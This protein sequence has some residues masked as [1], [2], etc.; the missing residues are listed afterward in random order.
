[1]ER[2]DWPGSFHGR[3]AHLEP[4]TSR[5]V[6]FLIKPAENLAGFNFH[7]VSSQLYASSFWMSPASQALVQPIPAMNGTA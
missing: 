6:S 1:V 2:A 4:A 3:A 7:R 5:V